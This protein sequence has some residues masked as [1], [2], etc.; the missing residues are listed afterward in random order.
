MQKKHVRNSMCFGAWRSSCVL[1]EFNI[2]YCDTLTQY[3]AWSWQT[4]RHF[5]C[6]MTEKLP[7]ITG[8]QDGLC[9]LCGIFHRISRRYST[10]W[11]AIWRSI[12]QAEEFFWIGQECIFDRGKKYPGLR[13][14]YQDLRSPLSS[15]SGHFLSHR[16]RSSQPHTWFER[17]NALS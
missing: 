2:S 16:I 7:L 10:S 5:R 8:L 13:F 11:T 17:Y 3:W 14:L 9:G 12:L 4:A 6:A 15:I 1:V